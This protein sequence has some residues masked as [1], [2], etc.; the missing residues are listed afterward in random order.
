MP[1]QQG[2]WTAA[3]SE[4]AFCVIL[5]LVCGPWGMLALAAS[6][7]CLLQLRCP[8]QQ[9]LNSLRASTGPVTRTE[10]LNLSNNSVVEPTGT[11]S[12]TPWSVFLYDDPAASLNGSDWDLDPSDMWPNGHAGASQEGSSITFNFTGSE[13]SSASCVWLA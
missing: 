8:H 7:A 2:P 13:A 4:A 9:M 1:E 10:S 3:G 11:L 12:N 6:R 5:L